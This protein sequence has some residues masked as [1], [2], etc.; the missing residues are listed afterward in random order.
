MTLP[1]FD[2]IGGKIKKL[3]FIFTCKLV[4]TPKCGAG[5]ARMILS[6]SAGAASPIE[7]GRL[8]LARRSLS[9]KEG[10]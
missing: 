4:G 6:S 10:E 9:A 5:L 3:F 8:R 1:Y 7:A 2:V